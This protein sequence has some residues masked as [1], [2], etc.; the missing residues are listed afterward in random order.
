LLSPSLL[1]SPT[2]SVPN[3]ICKGAIN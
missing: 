2:L 3:P 1:G